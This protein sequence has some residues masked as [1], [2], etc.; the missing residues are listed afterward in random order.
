M[1]SHHTAIGANSLEH[2]DRYDI[3]TTGEEWYISVKVGKCFRLRDRIDIARANQI[4]CLNSADQ[5][6]VVL[7]I[8]TKLYAL[9]VTLEYSLFS[10]AI[11][12]YSLDAILE[13][14]KA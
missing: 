12:L 2:K 6:Q 3:I 9:H 13:Y 7:D 10:T 1:P 5:S 11:K 14:S 8:A 4:R